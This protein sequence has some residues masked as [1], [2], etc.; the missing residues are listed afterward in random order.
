VRNLTTTG[1]RNYSLTL[2]RDLEFIAH[3]CS[4]VEI[5]RSI[6][7]GVVVVTRAGSRN[8]ERISTAVH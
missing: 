3:Q 4:A 2:I 1:N 7:V 6:H 8:L 5:R